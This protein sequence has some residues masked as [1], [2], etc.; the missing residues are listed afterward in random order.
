MHNHVYIDLLADSLKTHESHPALHIKRNGAYQSWTYGS[1]RRDLNRLCGA[2]EKEGLT[3][4]TT[5]VV[6]GENTPEWI[7]AYH[8]IILTRA[9]VVPIDPHIPPVEIEA[10]VSATNPM[11]VFCSPVFLPLF[12]RLQKN[13]ASI[14]RLVALANESNGPEPAFIRYRDGG[15]ENG[16][17]FSKDFAPDDPLAILFTSGTTG[18]PKGVVLSQK[19]LTAAGLYAVPRMNLSS[20]DTVCAVLPFHHV[21][22]CAASVVGALIA[23]LDIVCVPEIKGPLIIEALRDKSVTYFPAVPKMLQLLYDNIIQNVKNKPL[24]VRS[25]FKAMMGMCAVCGEALSMGIRRRLFSGVHRA[26]GGKL[27]VII[28]GGA[29]LSNVYWQGF[30]RLGFYIVEGYGLTET[31]GPI[32]V[33]PGDRPR[34]GSVGPAIQGNEIRI[35]ADKGAAVGEVLLRGTCVFSG[36]YRNESLTG[37]VFDNDGWFHTGD[38]GRVD[39]DGYLFLSGRKK[40]VIVLDNGK[41]VY[42]DEIED[43]FGASPLIEEI[44][45]FGVKQRE[46]EIVAAIVVPDKTTRKSQ[47]LAKATETIGKELIRMGKAIP[48]YRRIMDF[49]V[50]YAPLPRTTTRKLKKDELRAIYASVKHDAVVKPIGKERLTVMELALMETDAYRKVCEAISRIAPKTDPQFIIPRSHMQ[51]DLGFDSLDLIQLADQLEKQCDV[52]LPEGFFDKAETVG[53]LSALMDEQMRKKKP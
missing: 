24:P 6:I 50:V 12:R 21:F 16:D 46:R 39:K 19:N 3:K 48:A 15:D 37:D 27:R 13:H 51:I 17:A 10:I 1:L 52:P 30:R 41:N 34:R 42:P 35:A 31:F 44:G 7:I 14:K 26:F 29:A 22:G 40:D 45:I 23:G 11:V 38:L 32:T 47:L 36:Y 25:V 18:V 9:C 49:V 4:G 28:S 5:A 8:G 53:E 33:C 2:L 20:D 43:Y